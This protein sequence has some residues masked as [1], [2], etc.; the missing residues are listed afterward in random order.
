MA[1]YTV[2]TNTWATV[3]AV[4]TP[5]CN[6]TTVPT[7]EGN[8]VFADY[9]GVHVFDFATQAWGTTLPL[10]TGVSL[11]SETALVPSDGHLYLVAY[12]GTNDNV[13]K[14]NLN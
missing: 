4:G 3:P 5:N 6:Y 13:Y 12:D 1:V 7:W 9:G 11:Q 2:S 10:P 14:W 8:M